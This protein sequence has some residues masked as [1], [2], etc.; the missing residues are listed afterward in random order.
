MRKP[1]SDVAFSAAVKAEQERLGSRENYALAERNAEDD[2]ADRVTPA[3]AEFLA[4]RDTVF[5]ATASAAGQPYVQHRGGPPGFVRV[6]DEKKLGF[7]D[8]SGNRQYITLGNLS[9][10][11]RAMLF[12]PDFLNR[13]RIKIWGTA[14]VRED[15]PALQAKLAMPEYK[16]RV[17]RAILF[18]VQAWDSNCPSHI[19][20]RF[21]EAELLA[22]TQ[23]MQARIAELE[24]E[25]ERLQSQP[26]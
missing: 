7:A 16:A 1:N 8:F 26:R 11:P 20:R 13:R 3:L 10:N 23:G 12:F 15:D 22:A 5:L 19:Q 21:S 18:H 9:E 6:L 2:W 4:A 25:V 14:E 24:A 17:E